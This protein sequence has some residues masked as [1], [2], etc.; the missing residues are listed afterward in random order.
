MNRNVYY[1]FTSKTNPNQCFFATCD[2]PIAGEGLLISLG[3]E[4]EYKTTTITK[5]EY[6][7]NTKED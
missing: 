5:E 1:K 2:Y 7:K 6:E 3:M 4:G